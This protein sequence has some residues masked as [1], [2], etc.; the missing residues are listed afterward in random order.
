MKI[1]RYADS[2]APSI[3]PQESEQAF[4]AINEL[5]YFYGLYW[6]INTPDIFFIFYP[7]LKGSK[8][9]TDGSFTLYD[10]A[11]L[12]ESFSEHLER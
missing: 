1:G 4:A 2:L 7:V 10:G 12:A 8:T 5:P 3:R 9:L 11:G 6:I